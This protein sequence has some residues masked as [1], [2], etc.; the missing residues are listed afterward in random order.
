MG[1][2]DSFSASDVTKL[3][4]MYTCSNKKNTYQNQPY[5]GNQRPYRAD[6][7]RAGGFGLLGGA[8]G[9]YFPQEQ[10]NGYY[11]PFIPRA[12]G[13]PGGPAG[14]N[15]FN[16]GWLGQLAQFFGWKSLIF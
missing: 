1:Q 2:R 15:P 10:Y 13:G 3:N 8:T 16:L 9:P 4:R 5:Y 14:P 7:N 6:N 11:G 12:P